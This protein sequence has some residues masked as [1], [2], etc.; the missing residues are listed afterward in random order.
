VAGYRRFTLGVRTEERT[1]AIAKAAGIAG[2]DGVPHADVDRVAVRTVNDARPRGLRCRDGM[3]AEMHETPCSM[4]TPE[5]PL[6]DKYEAPVAE[7][8]E[9]P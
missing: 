7:P 3:R 4:D 8:C 6:S 2:V 9:Q 5:D 1:S